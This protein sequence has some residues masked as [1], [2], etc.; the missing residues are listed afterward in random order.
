MEKSILIIGAPNTF[1]TTM[2]K[3]L[4]SRFKSDEVVF[5]DL[6]GREPHKNPFLFSP[7]DEKTKLVIFDGLRNIHDVKHIFP[8][9]LNPVVVNKRMQ[10]SYK[11]TPQFI[12]IC[13]IEFTEQELIDL[14]PGFHRHFF[15]VKCIDEK[16]YA[17]GK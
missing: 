12:L 14:G 10:E 9:A 17:S 2:A 4:A 7:C 15:V 1:K 8:V 3:S 16:I 6:E 13:D 11:I 5:M